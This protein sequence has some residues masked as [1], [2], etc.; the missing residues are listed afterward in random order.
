MTDQAAGAFRYFSRDSEDGREYKGW[1]TW[2]QNKLLTM[3][4]LP[5]TPKGAF[6][7]ALLSGKALEAVEH[8][9]AEEYRRKMVASRFGSFCASGSL[10]WMSWMGWAR[11]SVR[12]SRSGQKKVRQ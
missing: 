11:Y 6:I 1:K 10:S 2:A 5:E 3:D 7:Y 8:L 4:K 12:C 9:K